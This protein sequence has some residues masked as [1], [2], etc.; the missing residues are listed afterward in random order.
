MHCGV[1]PGEG[2]GSKR[3]SLRLQEP[4]EDDDEDEM[5]GNE[6]KSR[7]KMQDNPPLY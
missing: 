2:A 3:G 6:Q 7:R 5:Y 1:L 4:L